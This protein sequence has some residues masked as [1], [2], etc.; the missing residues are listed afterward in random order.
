MRKFII[1]AAVCVLALTGGAQEAARMPALTV[2]QILAKNAEARG[3]AGKLRALQSVGFTGKMNIGP[4][5]LPLTMVK[6]RP[7][8]MKIELT[9]QGMTG[10]QAYDGSSGW[11]VMPFLGK[12]DPEAMS[13]DELSMAREQA[14][15]DG[16]FFDVEKKGH[17]AELAGMGEVDGKPAYKVKLTAKD[18][19]ETIAWFDATSFLQIRV[20]AKRKQQGQDVQAETILGDYKEF[21]G[22]LWPMSIVLRQNGSPA[23]QTITF[24]NVEI[25]PTL[26]DSLFRMPAKPG[27]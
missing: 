27:A 18:G 17:K 19:L 13:G 14:D 3:G 23:A 10:V 8:M 6:K 7:S 25:N 22:I 20:D 12:K 9:L 5:E 24:T 15:F 21:G 11:M 4:M 2:E 16:A 1:A 26:N